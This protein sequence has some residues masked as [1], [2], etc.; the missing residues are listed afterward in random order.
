M[1]KWP[2]CG[3]RE[4][5]CVSLGRSVKTPNLMG[6]RGKLDDVVVLEIDF[7]WVEIG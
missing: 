1:E 7:V 3:V 4:S 5:F 2:I 6:C